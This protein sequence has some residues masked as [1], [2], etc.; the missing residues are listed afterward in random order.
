[1]T[2]D[3]QVRKGVV[4]VLENEA[5][6][7]IFKIGMTSNLQNRIAQMNNS[8]SIPLPFRCMYAAVVE[9]PVFVEQQLHAAFA[10]HR[11][12]PR[13]EFFRMPPECI[14]A[15]IELVAT[16]VIQ[17]TSVWPP[18]PPQSETAPAYRPIVQLLGSSPTRDRAEADLVELLKSDGVL[19]SQNTLSAKWQI[20]RS[21]LSDWLNVFEQ[22]GL[23]KRIIAGRQHMLV[24]PDLTEE[25]ARAGLLN[26]PCS[27]PA[28][29]DDEPLASA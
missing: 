18:S 16:E 27:H 19:P 12:S 10:P 28:Q 29:D 17:P 15:A 1:M 23:V 21:T 11:V 3:T 7:G 9:D 4:Y 13:R 25:E 20:P 8:T 22:K 26:G 14:I 24:R 2:G 5:M 6:P